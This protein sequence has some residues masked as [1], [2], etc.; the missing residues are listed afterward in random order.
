MRALKRAIALAL[1][2]VAPSVASGELIRFRAADGTIGLVDH[3]SKLPPGATVLGVADETKSAPPAKPAPDDAARDR[4]RGGL[5]GRGAEPSLG[6]QR[7][8]LR[9]NPG[10]GDVGDYEGGPSTGSAGWCQR[11]RSAQERLERAEERLASAEESYDR[12]DEG[13]GVHEC[14]RS[15][16]E[17]AERELANAEQG[18]SQVEADCR[19]AGCNPGWLRCAP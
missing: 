6:R 13:G 4:L 19:S 3:P 10:S 15:S 7:R 9:M 1:L 17:A 8:G 14:S 16:L 2:L 12:C 18:L 5:E 11:G